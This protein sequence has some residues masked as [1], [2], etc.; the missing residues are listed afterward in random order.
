MKKVW[1][2]ALNPDQANAGAVLGEIRKYGLDGNGHFWTDDLKNMAWLGVAE[3]LLDKDTALW[4]LLGSADDLKINSVRY[5]LSLLA[6]HIQAQRG[7]NYPILFV[8]TKDG[9]SAETL[10]TPLRGAGCIQLGNASLGAKIVARAHTPVRK[11]D[12]E[13]R[14]GI[15]ANPGFGVWLEVGPRGGNWNGALAGTMGGG[16]ID[17]HGVGAA[18]ELPKKARL[19][20]PMKGLKLTLEKREYSAWAVRNNLDENMSYYVRIKDMPQS[21]LFGPYAAEDDA[22]VHVY[23][24]L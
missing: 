4:V 21:V 3:Q 10:P 20:Y 6:L 17:F 15:H 19:E 16:E 12:M 5:G 7:H 2:T 24:L 8:D 9:V 1:V 22:S 13:Y 23:E 14:I 11:A 18:G